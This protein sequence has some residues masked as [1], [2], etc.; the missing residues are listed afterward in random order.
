MKSYA[1]DLDEAESG[2]EAIELVRQTRYDII[3]MDHMMPMMDGIEAAMIIRRQC[4]ENGK[5]PP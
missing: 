3:F 1:F 4:G 2:P 5:A